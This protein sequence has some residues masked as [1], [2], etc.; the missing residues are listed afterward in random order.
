MARA[1]VSHRLVAVLAGLVV[2]ACCACAPQASTTPGTGPALSPVALDL[3]TGSGDQPARE[4]Q[5]DVAE[6]RLT[7][8]CMTAR[9]LTYLRHEPLPP[10]GSDEERAADL[11]RRR[12][13]GYGLGS[14]GGGQPPPD[15]DAGEPAYERALFGDP[16]H[17]QEL[18]L[19]DGSLHTFPGDGCI[20]QSR[21][22]LYGDVNRWAR[23]VSVPPVIDNVLRDRTREAPALTRANARWTSC[24]A[25]A[26]FPYPTPEA[27][28]EDLSAAYTGHGSTP[29]LR[30][31]ETA[32][33]V[34]DGE[35][36]IRAHVPAADLAVRREA[37]RSLPAEQREELNELA[38]LQCAASQHAT[39]ITGHSAPV[40]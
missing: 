17:R 25:A 22:E 19:P 5:L 11:P 34:A 31:R 35:C 33:A 8:R 29:A 12:T 4:Q 36:A 30:A 28:I 23:V 14:S 27:A 39:R 38:T 1:T 6:E 40:C 16:R 3:V 21:T 10:N 37:A 24:M 9:G 20:A 7:Q 2:L 15:P 18:R 13:V 32:T 26:G